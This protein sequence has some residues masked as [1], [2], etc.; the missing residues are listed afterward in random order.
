M[1]TSL[2]EI[3]GLQPVA[4]EPLSF[5][6][7]YEIRAFLLE[8][9][10]GNILLYNT[11]SLEAEVPA[12]LAGGGVQ[13]QYLNHEHESMFGSDRGAHG[14]G[15]K[16]LV[17]RDDAAMVEGRGWTLTQTFSRRHTLDDD[18][19]V[20]P[21]PGHTPGATAY[22]WD[23][24]EAR[25]LFTGDSLYVREGEWVDALLPSSDRERYLGSLQ[26]LSELE[27]DYLVPWPTPA[28]GPYAFGVTR[29]EARE[30]ITAVIDN[31]RD[32]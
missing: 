29:D 15:A 9:R 20:I 13:R 14:L 10:R 1:T 8:R 4:V 21:I 6:Q 28:G 7:D 18:F 23:S 25:V 31:L 3:T 27:F 17:H 32:R 12:L 24:G 19:E 22:L 30:R 2:E 26:L 11:G 16:L 5:D